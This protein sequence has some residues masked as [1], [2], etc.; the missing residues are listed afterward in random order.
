MVEL[1]T[2]VIISAGS[3]LLLGYWFRYACLL[4]LIA[5]TPRDYACECARTNRLFFPQIR[6]KLR[7]KA[8]TNFDRL[9]ECLDRD[10]AILTYLLE[11]TTSPNDEPE[12]EGL[13][14]AIYYRLLSAVYLLSR[15]FSIPVASHAIEEMSLVVA[16][17]ANAMGERAACVSNV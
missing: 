11:H 10:Y 17:F 15:P 9:H 2:T 1:V 16:H 12:F 13:I 3:V 14:L 8:I 4:I 6:S 7:E 5:K